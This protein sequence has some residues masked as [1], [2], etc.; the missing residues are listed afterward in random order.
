MNET[1][2]P[3]FCNKQFKPLLT[4]FTMAQWESCLTKPTFVKDYCDTKFSAASVA[5]STLVQQCQSPDFANH[6]LPEKTLE[7]CWDL[8]RYLQRLCV[9]NDCRQTAG[10]LTNECFELNQPPIY[11]ARMIGMYEGLSMS[12]IFCLLVEL[13]VNARSLGNQ[14]TSIREYCSLRFLML[15]IIAISAAVDAA[16]STYKT[17]TYPNSPYGMNID[18][19]EL[20]NTATVT[21]FLAVPT[22]YCAMRDF[23]SCMST[24]CS[25][26]LMFS[27]GYAVVSGELD[28]E[29][30][31]GTSIEMRPI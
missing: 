22:M 11:D 10:S 25:G 24:R 15:S 2:T 23:Y 12:F 4:N 21:M 31:P 16:N 17:F 5:V 3:E 18:D 13:F 26:A 19:K 20:A 8:T 7:F 27:R 9:G 14:Q 29:S 30:D 28:H 6:Y 1:D